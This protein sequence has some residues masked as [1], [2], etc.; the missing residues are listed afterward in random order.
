MLRLILIRHGETERNSQGRLQGGLSDVPL[1]ER[2]RE[3]ARLLGLALSG[4][5]LEAVYSSPLSRALATAECICAHHAFEVRPVPALAELDMGTID[6]LDRAQV[7]EQHPN[8]WRHWQE[9][10][11]SVALPGGESVVEL[12]RRAWGAVEDIRRRHGEG[13]VALVGH[14][15]ALQTIIAAA[16]GEPLSTFR[17]YHLAVAS[18]SVLHLADH[19]SSL[20]KLNDTVHLG[21]GGPALQRSHRP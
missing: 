16:V 1:N 5:K 3:Q 18:I 9:A 10:D 8:F 15:L 13:S 11:Y 21:D 20:A 7:V 12:Q 2:G 17:K 6:G 4:E 19:R 14:G